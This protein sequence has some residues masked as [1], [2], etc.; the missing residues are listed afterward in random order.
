MATMTA[1]GGRPVARDEARTFAAAT[2]PPAPGFLHEALFYD[3]DDGFLAGTLPFIAGAVAKDEPVMVAVAA[4]KI[5]LLR[6]QLDGWAHGVTF[7]D[8]GQI[9]GNPARIIP[10][11]HDFLAGAG[12]RPVRGVGEPIGP[13]RSPGALLECQ[14]HEMLL[15]TAFDGGSPWWLLCPYDTAALATGVVEEAARSHPF[16]LEAAAHR[17]S[18]RYGNGHPAGFDEALP[19]PSGPFGEL[20][21]DYGPLGHVR[22]FVEWHASRHGLSGPRLTDLLVAVN[23]A[24]TNSVCHGGGKGAIR[25]WRDGDELLCEVHDHGTIAEPLAGRRRPGRSG[26]GGRGLWMIHQLCDLVE[27]RSTEDGTTVRMHL[28]LG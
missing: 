3:G 17:Q 5:D 22:S 20:R 21:F 15:N 27:L 2:A 25:V 1:V 4:R 28:S 7:V 18:D 23:E 8:M 16:I 12:E 19:D 6:A 13:D 26:E 14:Q 24:A 11:W 9:G 10:A